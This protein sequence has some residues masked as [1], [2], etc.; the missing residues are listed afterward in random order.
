MIGALILGLI[1]GAV[2]RLL[3]PGDALEQL[4]GWKSWAATVVLGLVGAF[5]GWLVF[6]G[7]FGIGDDSAFDLGG[8]VGA[9]IGSVLV[10]LA[11]GWVL[12]RSSHRTA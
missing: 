2:A 12:N 5:V 3:I 9:V 7:L 4:E 6:A 10:L 11:A 1:A 8:I